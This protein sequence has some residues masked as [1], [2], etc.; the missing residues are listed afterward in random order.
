MV[1]R[2]VTIPI[3]DHARFLASMRNWD[4]G[5]V[6]L[7]LTLCAGSGGSV[8]ITPLAENV[9]HWALDC[10]TFQIFA[11]PGVLPWIPSGALLGIVNLI[12]DEQPLVESF[13]LNSDGVC[14]CLIPPPLQFML[15]EASTNKELNSRTIMMA[16]TMPVKTFW[17]INS[18]DFLTRALVTVTLLEVFLVQRS[19]E[20]RVMAIMTTG[21]FSEHSVTKPCSQC[22]TVHRSLWLITDGLTGSLVSMGV[23]PRSWLISYGFRHQWV[24]V[25]WMASST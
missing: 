3:V 6:L 5:F 17:T 4:V 14:F 21:T 2:S 20:S 18:I 22:I 1:S 24:T 9:L 25:V 10:S 7:K 15:L 8:D 23:C 13:F 11:R 16:K 19:L 12:S